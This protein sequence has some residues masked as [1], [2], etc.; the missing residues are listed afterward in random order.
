MI[1]KTLFNISPKQLGLEKITPYS[2]LQMLGGIIMSQ[3]LQRL[4]L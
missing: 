2:S 3:L 4:V 1:F